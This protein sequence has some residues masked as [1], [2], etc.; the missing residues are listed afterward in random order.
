MLNK[1]IGSSNKEAK[2][3]YRRTLLVTEGVPFSGVVT[4][5]PT[6]E[7]LLAELIG[8]Y[9]ETRIPSMGGEL[10]AVNYTLRDWR[11]RANVPDKLFKGVLR[12][13]KIYWDYG[14]YVECTLTD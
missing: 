12:H 3:F 14:K 13:L 8:K 4:T 9:I 11:K 7:S 1:I 6:K 2:C 10:P 5:P